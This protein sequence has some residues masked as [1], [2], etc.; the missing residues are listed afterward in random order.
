M[1]IAIREKNSDEKQSSKKSDKKSSA[2][3]LNQEQKLTNGDVNINS[4]TRQSR[5]TKNEQKTKSKE[6]VLMIE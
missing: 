5:Y 3:N 4:S 6:H 2:K 1:A